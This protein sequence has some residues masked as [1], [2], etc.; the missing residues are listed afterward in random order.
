MADRPPFTRGLARWY[1]AEDFRDRPPST[2]VELLPEE[3]DSLRKGR[4]NVID[5]ETPIWRSNWH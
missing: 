3:W 4:K 5:Y 1:S 2:R